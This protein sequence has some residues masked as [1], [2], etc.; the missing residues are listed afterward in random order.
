MPMSGRFS[1]TSI[2]LPTHIEAIMPQKSCGL[3]VITCG[4]GAGAPGPIAPPLRAPTRVGGGLGPGTDFD[5]PLAELVRIF[6]AFFFQR[7]G[8]EG[9]KQRAPARQDAE[10]RT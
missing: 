5:P 6:R 7:G 9:R 10:R 3:S 4:P 1:T 2:R 8:G